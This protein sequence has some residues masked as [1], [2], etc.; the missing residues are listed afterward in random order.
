MVY[1]KAYCQSLD[2]VASFFKA[3]FLHFH[4]VILPGTHFSQLYCCL[5]RSNIV[6][7]GCCHD[8]GAKMSP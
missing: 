5:L 3:F 7:L 6:T 1:I 4:L 8:F 2:V